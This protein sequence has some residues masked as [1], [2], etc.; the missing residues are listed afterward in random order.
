MQRENTI[1]F[2]TNIYSKINTSNLI[3]AK[4][5]TIKRL[6]VASRYVRNASIVSYTLRNFSAEYNTAVHQTVGTPQNGYVH[7]S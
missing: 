1:Y 4:N 3:V 7:D 6:N 5:M 2:N